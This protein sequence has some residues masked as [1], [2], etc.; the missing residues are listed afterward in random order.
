MYLLAADIDSKR[1]DLEFFEK[2]V[3]PLLSSIAV[4]RA[5]DRIP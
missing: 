4:I 2:K 3:R 1:A 5:M